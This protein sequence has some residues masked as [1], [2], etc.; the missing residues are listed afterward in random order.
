MLSCVQK[1]SKTI[2]LGWRPATWS[3][4]W[5]IFALALDTV[6]LIFKHIGLNEM[7]RFNSQADRVQSLSSSNSCLSS[8]SMNLDSA[9]DFENQK[10]RTFLDMS[11][12]STDLNS[13]QSQSS[14]SFLFFSQYGQQLA[15]ILKFYFQLLTLSSDSLSQ[16][17]KYL[18]DSSVGS[19][20]VSSSSSSLPSIKYF[21]VRLQRI[22]L[23]L[24]GEVTNKV[25]SSPSS[26]S[27]STELSSS[28]SSSS[29]SRNVEQIFSQICA[30]NPVVSEL[31][32][33][34]QAFLSIDLPQGNMK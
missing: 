12:Q 14:V 22:L 20:A 16:L 5:S 24:T 6:E 2:H 25:S 32:I 4:F 29:T 33:Q 15:S 11:S 31:L 13:Q 27:A 3:M 28:P 7:H 10:K 8:Y 34:I 18:Y 17:L 26:A 9:T 1:V 23:A 19:S 30:D 21:R